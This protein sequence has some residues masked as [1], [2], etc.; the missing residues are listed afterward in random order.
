M[1]CSAARTVTA[2]YHIV[3]RREIGALAG[4]EMDARLAESVGGLCNAV[5]NGDC[6]T[7]V[8]VI[9]GTSGAG[10]GGAPA[11][12][13]GGRPAEG[14]GSGTNPNVGAKCGTLNRM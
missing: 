10:D 9:A 14:A 12:R 8:D 4:Q 7:L 1:A 5:H 3:L 2:E 6:V 13:V 11:R